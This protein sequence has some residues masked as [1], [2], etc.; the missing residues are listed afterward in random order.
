M[1]IME[2]LQKYTSPP[3]WFFLTLLALAVLTFTAVSFV[4][5]N[6]RKTYAKTL[7]MVAFVASVMTSTVYMTIYS[8]GMEKVQE[9]VQEKYEL[10]NLEIDAG[11]FFS[12]MN[13]SYDESCPDVEITLKNNKTFDYK[14]TPTPEGD[15]VLFAPKDDKDVPDFTELLENNPIEE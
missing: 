2:E 12:M 14:L 5:D 10:K 9:Y 8:N 15:L 1:N 4:V 11:Q 7:I 6:R 13:C 3:S